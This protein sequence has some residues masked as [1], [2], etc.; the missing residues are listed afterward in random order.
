MWP[1]FIAL[2]AL[3]S[4]QRARF[5]APLSKILPMNT[6]IKVYIISLNGYM[7][8]MNS[9]QIHVLVEL[10]KI[11]FRYFLDSKQSHGLEPIS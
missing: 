9:A 3:Y 5:V 4:F 1:G 8:C 7:I 10:N 6:P 11:H 2:L